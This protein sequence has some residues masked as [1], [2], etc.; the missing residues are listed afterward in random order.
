MTRHEQM[1]AFID[2]VEAAMKEG[3]PLTEAE[4]KLGPSNPPP[5]YAITKGQRVVCD[6]MGYTIEGVAVTNVEDSADQIAI[7]ADD[8]TVLN[9]RGDLCDEIIVDGVTI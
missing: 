6:G 7:C 2:A 8:G 5:S 9:V 3:R 1:I 4:R